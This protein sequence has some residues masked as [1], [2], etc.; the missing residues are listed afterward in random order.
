MA[1]ARLNT[2]FSNVDLLD[3]NAVKAYAQVE[4]Q[5]GCC[6]PGMQAG[7]AHFDTSPADLLRLYDVNEFAASVSVLAI[8]P[9]RSRKAAAFRFS[10]GDQRTTMAL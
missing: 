10:G 8:K 9:S 3:G 7:G 1:A 5:G 6:S 4:N 2:G